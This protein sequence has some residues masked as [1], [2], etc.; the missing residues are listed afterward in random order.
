MFKLLLIAAV[1]SVV[2]ANENEETR[3]QSQTY[4]RPEYLKPYAPFY[5]RH[6]KIEHEVGRY[7]FNFIGHQNED[8]GIHYGQYKTYNS[9]PYIDNKYDYGHVGQKPSY[10]LYYSPHQ[11][12]H[13]ALSPLYHSRNHGYGYLPSKEAYHNVLILG[14]VISFFGVACEELK[15]HQNDNVD[16]LKPQESYPYQYINVKDDYQLNNYNYA[17]PDVV[18]HKYIQQLEYSKYVDGL[19]KHDGYAPHI[20]S[21][22][23]NNPYLIPAKEVPYSTTQKPNDYQDILS[24][25]ALNYYNDAVYDYLKKVVVDEKP[26]H[27]YTPQYVEGNINDNLNYAYKYNPAHYKVGEHEEIQNHNPN[28]LP[29]KIDSEPYY[30]RNAHINKPYISPLNIAKGYPHAVSYHYT[31][32]DIE[33]LSK[34]HEYNLYKKDENI[35]HLRYGV[36]KPH[37]AHLGLEKHHYPKQIDAKYL[38]DEYENKALKGFKDIAVAVKDILFPKGN[39]HDYVNTKEHEGQFY[40]PKRHYGKLLGNTVGTL[41]PYKVRPPSYVPAEYRRYGVN[42]EDEKKHYF[43][44]HAY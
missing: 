1:I 42:H 13:L 35:D 21:H 41:H 12:P 43:N 33:R 40:T 6:H 32:A 11:T 22:R 9:H 38:Y 27:V 24:K 44:P 31:P 14:G 8:Y 10:N 25:K 29:R 4:L 5:P 28:Y 20:D 16:G 39:Y 36:Y 23:H 18:D 34:S 7:H 19:L 17:K 15:V 26:K 37:D 30:P 2:A 3:H